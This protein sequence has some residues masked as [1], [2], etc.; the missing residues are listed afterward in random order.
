MARALVAMGANAGARARTLA[1]ASATVGRLPLTRVVRASRLR[2]T[3]PESPRD[4]GPF[5]NGALLLETAL[6]P[7]ALLRELLT[8]E[9]RFG[10][11]RAPGERGGPR[12]LDLDLILHE[13]HTARGAGLTL[14]HPRFRGRR[15]VLEP[16]AEVA[17][18]LRD[19][20]SGRTVA[21][22]WAALTRA[23]PRT[24]GRA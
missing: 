15:F 10:R 16:A 5:L 9:R 7:R 8:L 17:P 12:A 22:L 14:P 24:R 20:H 3:D 1:A 2:E 6:S 23:K 13:G 18:Q 11:R 4:G 19:P 21:E